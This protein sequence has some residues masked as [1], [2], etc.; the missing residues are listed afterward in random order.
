VVA[1]LRLLTSSRKI[2]WSRPPGGGVLLRRAVRGTGDRYVTFA[3]LRMRENL[4]KIVSSFV[5]YFTDL[6]P[7]R[8]YNEALIASCLNSATRDM[9]KAFIQGY[10]HDVAYEQFVRGLFADVDQALE[11]SVYVVK[12]GREVIWDPVGTPLAAFWRTHGVRPRVEPRHTPWD[13][14][15]TDDFRLIVASRILT[16]SD[17][18]VLRGGLLG[19]LEGRA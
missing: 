18:T 7:S 5:S 1:G 8:R 16:R 3:A 4:P 6:I 10:D 2:V 12:D 14:I 15:G 11:W 13:L 17:L 9:R 19:L